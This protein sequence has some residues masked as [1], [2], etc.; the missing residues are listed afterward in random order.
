VGGILVKG[1]AALGVGAA[2]LVAALVVLGLR[3][4]AARQARRQVEM[5]MVADVAE[6]AGRGEA[7]AAEMATAADIA[8]RYHLTQ[9]ARVLAA[10][11]LVAD[12]RAA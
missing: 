2:A 5:R 8:D 9:T 1:F 3:A 12:N 7:S 6:R 10:R 4:D 11:A